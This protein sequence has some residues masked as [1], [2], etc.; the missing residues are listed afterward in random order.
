LTPRYYRCDGIIANMTPFRGPS[1]DAGTAYEMGVAAALNKVVIA[2][3]SDRT[4]YTEK[5]VAA[6]AKRGEDGSL[7]DAEG[8][9]VEDFLGEVLVDNLMLAHGVDNVDNKICETPEEAIIMAVK[10]WNEKVN[11]K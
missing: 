1:M 7:R 4:P 6:G 3:S 11:S 5:C 9:A 10:V 8:M 2:Y